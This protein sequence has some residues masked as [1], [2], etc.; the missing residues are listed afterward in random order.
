M[1]SGNLLS[2]SKVSELKEALG[3]DLKSEEAALW[4]A[5]VLGSTTHSSMEVPSKTRSENRPENPSPVLLPSVGR[6]TQALENSESRVRKPTR[7][8]TPELKKP[9]LEVSG[10]DGADVL[11]HGVEPGNPIES[12]TTDEGD[13][14]AVIPMPGGVTSPNFLTR[15]PTVTP[16]YDLTKEDDDRDLSGDKTQK[17]DEDE[18]GLADDELNGAEI[19]AIAAPASLGPAPASLHA[20][21]NLIN[22]SEFG[23]PQIH[24]DNLHA[25]ASA[26][27]AAGIGAGGYTGAV[28]PEVM[29]P[30]V[31]EIRDGFFGLHQKAD[32][33]HQE[34]SQFGA[35]IQSHG[36]R[37]GTLE[38]VAS[39][40]TIR[41]E[42]SEQRTKQLEAKIEG[43]LLQQ[44]QGATRSRSPVRT[45]LGTGNRSPS[46]RSPRYTTRSDFSADSEDLDIVIGGWNDARKADAF[47]EVRNIFK[48]IQ[49]EH[50]ID[51]IWAPHG[52][53]TFAKVKLAFAENQTT[54]QARRQFQMQIVSKIKNKNFRSGIHG[55]EG[56]KV[57]A[58]K[59]KTP[60]ERAKIRAVVLTKEFY[61]N[62]ATEGPP[63][64][65][66]DQIEISWVGKVYIDHFQLLGS[67]ERD[68]EPQP[69]DAIIE[70]SKGNHMNW[71]I[72]AEEFHRVTGRPKESLQQIWLESGP[73][74]AHS[75]AEA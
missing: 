24:N 41:H 8:D 60:E 33:I 42:T 21:A 63:K 20:P 11:M 19:D 13:E 74:S 70:D 16:H 58:T 48:N 12:Q 6:H 64:F 3:Y 10:K 35:E 7:P 29:P 37:L 51:D 47:D 17:D 67:V 56:L 14:D 5:R 39:E 31:Q 22:N 15:A 32:R 43:L 30:W 52:R 34:M 55:S 26:G 9:K 49:A 25:P 66:E 40:H 2:P 36:V 18:S 54:L 57:W 71:Y 45:G 53:T 27:A 75:R 50:A 65:D 46:P 38:Q 28:F 59:S 62:V 1:S 69:Y 44:E 73:T 68:G 72:R 4:K 23:H 61:K